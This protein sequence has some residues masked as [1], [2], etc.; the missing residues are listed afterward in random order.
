MNNIKHKKN[1]FVM[2]EAIIVSV[3][4]FLL[5]I[6][7]YIP[8][9]NIIYKYKIFEKY[10]TVDD[11]YALNSIKVFLYQNYNVNRLCNYAYNKNTNENKIIPLA[12]INYTN[13]NPTVTTNNLYSDPTDIN[14]SEKNKTIF[15]KMLIDLKVKYLIFTTYDD[16]IDE[17][18]SDK[19]IL[20]QI[21]NNV[22]LL[23]Y[24]TFL[25]K[26]DTNTKKNLYRLI[27]VFENDTYASI[28]MYKLKEWEETI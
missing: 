27:A 13:T 3:M 23:N 5:F 4:I 10:D 15:T 9:V 1:G 28:N 11:L 16:M 19:N 2:L 14:Y 25:E 20:Y 24:I 12:V 21:K 7:I 26:K 8:S 6:A 22:G 17:N 18:N